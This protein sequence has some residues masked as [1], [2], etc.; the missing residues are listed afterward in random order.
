MSGWIKLHRQFKDNGH[1]HMPDRALK[2]WLYI[3]LSVS[4]KDRPEAGLR[5]GEAWISYDMIARDC[6]DSPNRHMRREAVAQALKYLEENGYIERFITKGKGQRI[7]VVNW[8]KYQG[9][10]VVSSDT[11]PA[12]TTS[13]EIGPHDDS[14]V[15]YSDHTS[16]DNGPDQFRIRT[17]QVPYP[18]HASSV[19][20]PSKFRI[21]TTPV[22]Y[23]D[24]TGPDTELIQEIKEEEEVKERENDRSTSLSP[25]DV[26]SEFRPDPEMQKVANHY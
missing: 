25:V 5:A 9:G 12:G 22:P 26:G 4:H 7:R 2:I 3:L 14:Q 1:F 10:D 11:E 20:G 13:S 16:S 21:R 15:P 17:T 23:S 6:G 24:H 8:S 18:D 19:S